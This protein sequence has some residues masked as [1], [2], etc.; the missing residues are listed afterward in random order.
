MEQFRIFAFMK[1][2]LTSIVFAAGLIGTSQAQTTILSET[3]NSG[4]PNNW[5]VVI[6]D[7]STVDSLVIA[8]EDGWVTLVDPVDSTDTIVGSTSFFTEPAEASR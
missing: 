2:L 6:D 4:I 5:T 3:F 1:H 8:F 7:T